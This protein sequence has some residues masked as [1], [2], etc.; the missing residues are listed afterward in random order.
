MFYV[1]AERHNGRLV[2]DTITHFKDDSEA[3]ETCKFL[4]ECLRMDDNMPV[5]G[6]VDSD[7]YE[8]LVELYAS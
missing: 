1:K 3:L 8:V 2:L 5:Y 7:T 6:V 4:T